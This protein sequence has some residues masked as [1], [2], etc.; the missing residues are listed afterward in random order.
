MKAA[1]LTSSLLATKGTA[2]P[3][4]SP[5]TSSPYMAP[6]VDGY[7][8]RPVG[9]KTPVKPTVCALHARAKPSTD[10]QHTPRAQTAEA[11]RLH[12][13]LKPTVTVKNK[14]KRFHNSVHL[15]A[16]A[17]KMLRMLAARNECSLQMIIEQAVTRYLNE[18]SGVLACIC[19]LDKKD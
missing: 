15:D 18:E 3:T 14:D 13:T 16:Q 11:P 8:L 5:E 6:A 17:H 19:Q 1:S 4:L 2:R 12:E 7:R 10:A 9:E